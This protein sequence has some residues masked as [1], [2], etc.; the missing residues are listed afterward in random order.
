MTAPPSSDA[1]VESSD[2]SVVRQVLAPYGLATLAQAHAAMPP[3]QY[4][5]ILRQVHGLRCAGR[6]TAAVM[7]PAGP[8]Q[9]GR[10]AHLLERIAPITLLLLAAM[11]V[12]FLVESLQPGGSESADTLYAMGAIT[13][14]TLRDGQA[15]R[16]VT[17]CF[18]HIGLVHLAGNAM[19]LFWLGRLA[20]RLYGPLRYLGIFIAAGLGG[21]L[22]SVWVAPALEAGA[23]GAIWGLMGA[24]LMGSWRNRDVAGRI[25]GKEIR[26][27]IIAVV[28]LNAIFSFSP[29]VSLSAHL[30][31][32]LTGAILALCMPFV[33]P[34]ESRATVVACRV[35]SASAVVVAVALLLT[36]L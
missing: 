34:R 15:W 7:E 36:A 31:G 2:A 22:L 4:E 21:A 10:R 19:T 23:S 33:S 24:L 32:C 11:A 16:L 8:A 25:S 30:G 5:A 13:P 26:Q 6:D 17:S 12:V 3:H 28:I 35:G 29:G 14:D 20:E 27:S 18:L 9:P 1:T